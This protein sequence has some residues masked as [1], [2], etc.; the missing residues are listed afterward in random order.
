MFKYFKKILIFISALLILF[1][2][3]EFIELY[4]LLRELHPSIG[5]GFI[6]IVAVLLAYFAIWPMV[7]ILKMPQ[8][9]KPQIRARNVEAIAAQRMRRFRGNRFLLK[10]GFDFSQVEDDQ[11]GYRK[12]I[13][14][15][16]VEAAKF[17]KKYITN[18]FYASSISQNGFIDAVLILS[19]NVNLVK[20]T[21]TLYNGRTSNRDLFSIARQI[22]FSLAIGGSE[23][24][25][26]AMDES[27]S[28]LATEGMKSIPF[29]DKVLGSLADGFVNACLLTRVALITENYCKLITIDSSK[30]LYP[31]PSVIISSTRDITADIYSRTRNVLKEMSRKRTE[32]VV[33][34]ANYA[35]NPARYVMSKAIGPL[36]EKTNSSLRYVTL[37]SFAPLQNLFKKRW[38]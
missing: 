10:S 2:A 23:A 20:E 11:D 7:K 32:E 31:S 9:F 19:A 14:A 38:K 1:V 22:Y 13:A 15:L 28:K 6:V 5:Y 35:L 18:L 25:E 30:D 26:Y 4:V 27:I 24:I 21:F 16:E 17:R 37:K 29:L 36:A 34:F 8:G 3:R 33:S 12:V